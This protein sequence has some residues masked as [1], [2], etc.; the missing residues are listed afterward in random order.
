M[1]DLVK[2]LR[3]MAA[4]GWNPIGDEAADLITTLRAEVER[5][6]R[7]AMTDIV[8]RLRLIELIEQL[9]Q[10]ALTRDD[11]RWE[12]ADTITVL[13]AENERLK[14]ALVAAQNRRTPPH[15]GGCDL[16]CDPCDCGY[17]TWMDEDAALD[18]VIDAALEKEASA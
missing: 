7:E 10:A 1:I 14:A 12:A 18:R 16:K 17:K 5:L 2:R 3:T 6:E 13:R 9:R 15:T 8:E 4:T 11:Y